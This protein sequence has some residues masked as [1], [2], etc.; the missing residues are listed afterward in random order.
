MGLGTQAACPHP[1][2]ATCGQ[3]EAYLRTILHGTGVVLAG[4]LIAW[5][6]PRVIA[7][8]G[9]V[10]LILVYVVSVSWYLFPK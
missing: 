9:S 5:L 8:A 10:C 1:L 4:F 3:A 6:T 7:V 2:G